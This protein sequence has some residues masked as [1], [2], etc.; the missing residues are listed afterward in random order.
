MAD[1]HEIVV[2]LQALGGL[3]VHFLTPWELLRGHRQERP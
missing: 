1:I 2:A 3:I